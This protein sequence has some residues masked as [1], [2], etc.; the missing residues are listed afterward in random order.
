VDVLHRIRINTYLLQRS[1]NGWRIANASL[2]GNEYAQQLR[3][4]RFLIL[5]LGVN[6]LQVKNLSATH[7]QCQQVTVVQIIRATPQGH[8]AGNLVRRHHGVLRLLWTLSLGI[9]RQYANSDIAVAFW[10]RGGS[11]VSR[12]ELTGQTTEGRNQL[13]GWLTGLR[14]GSN[15]VVRRLIQVLLVGTGWVRW[16]R[17]EGVIVKEHSWVINVVARQD[18]TLH[19]EHVLWVAEVRAQLIRD[20][21]LWLDHAWEHTFPCLQHWVFSIELVDFHT[22]VISIDGRFNGVTDVAN[23]VGDQTLLSTFGIQSIR[24]SFGQALTL[25]IREAIQ[26]GVA[27]DDPL[28]ASVNDRW[29]G[30]GVSGQPWRDL[31]D[32]LTWIAVVEDL[33][34]RA[35][36]VG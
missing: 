31:F 30:L 34:F 8:I 17:P 11:H 4:C 22:A 16:D 12:Q 19:L 9:G 23:T 2:I 10:I 35:N 36:T 25:G 7:W 5:T 20:F 28:D 32:A 33:G 6:W 27:I 14:I 18:G 1:V 3:E 15:Y 24:S 21:C 13:E 29:V 26:S